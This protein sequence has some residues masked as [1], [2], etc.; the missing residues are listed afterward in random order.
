[1]VISRLKAGVYD[2]IQTNFIVCNGRYAFDGIHLTEKEKMKILEPKEFKEIEDGTHEGSIIQIDENVIRKG[3]EY[4]DFFITVDDMKKENGDPL[5]LKA[6]YP[7]NLHEKSMLGEF[8]MRCGFELGEPGDDFDITKM[9]GTTVRY[10]TL[11]S[12]GGDGKIYANIL[13]ET[14]KIKPKK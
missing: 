4:V 8:I 12:A 7:A 10:Q 1:M 11:S 14:V 9:R 6:S 13:R 2:R 3:F 5:T